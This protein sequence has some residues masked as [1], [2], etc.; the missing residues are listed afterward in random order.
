MAASI[1]VPPATRMSLPASV[2][3]GGGVPTMPLCVTFFSPWR[4]E[5]ISGRCKRAKQLGILLATDGSAWASVSG[6]PQQAVPLQI[7]FHQRQVA[8]MASKPRMPVTAVALC[9]PM[10]S[11]SH[12]NHRKPIGPVPMQTV[13]TPSMRER[14]SAGA[15]R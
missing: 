1:A 3:S 7:S 6:E 10:R 9:E 11:A 4:R 5:L 2:A 12:P 14:I 8:A 13:R 15:A